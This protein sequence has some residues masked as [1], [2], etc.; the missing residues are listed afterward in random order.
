MPMDIKVPA[1]TIAPPIGPKNI[2]AASATGAELSA[3]ADPST[4][5]DIN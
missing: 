2:L 1:V 3:R 4:P 5:I